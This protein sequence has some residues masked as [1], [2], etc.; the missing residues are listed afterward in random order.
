MHR[1]RQC[2]KNRIQYV[3]F[4]TADLLPH[5]PLCCRGSL[6]FMVRDYSRPQ[7]QLLKAPIKANSCS[8]REESAAVWD[9]KHAN[10]SVQ[11]QK[12]SHRMGRPSPDK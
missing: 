2:L 8:D 5:S 1:S 3:L 12:R 4:D 10:L 6:G 7:R 9:P 11:K